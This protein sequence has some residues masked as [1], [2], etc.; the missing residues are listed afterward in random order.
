[1]ILGQLLF[2]CKK[3]SWSLSSEIYGDMGMIFYIETGTV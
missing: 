1:M 3:N 2:I